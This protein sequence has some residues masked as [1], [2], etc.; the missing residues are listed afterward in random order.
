[1]R[2]NFVEAKTVLAKHVLIIDRWVE[3]WLLLCL[4]MDALHL[5]ITAKL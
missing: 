5:Q 1:M 4:V 2:G 3:A